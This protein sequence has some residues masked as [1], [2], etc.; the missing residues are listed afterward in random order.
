MVEIDPITGLPKELAAF[1]DLSREAQTI[2]VQI[3][4]KKFGKPYTTITGIDSRG[5]DAKE[6]LKALKAK[7][8]CGGTYKE[9]KIELQGNYLKGIRDAL[10]TQGFEPEN[11]EIKPDR[12]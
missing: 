7:F 9:G 8:A 4:K 12:R 11:I 10:V 5:I 1:E 6:V 2:T 3:I